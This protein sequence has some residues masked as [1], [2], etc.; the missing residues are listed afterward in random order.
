MFVVETTRIET[1]ESSHNITELQSTVLLPSILNMR[2]GGKDCTGFHCVYSW[3]CYPSSS[4]GNPVK[5]T[6]INSEFF[7]TLTLLL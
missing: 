6:P 1:F 5:R 7:P 3:H 2:R 4:Y